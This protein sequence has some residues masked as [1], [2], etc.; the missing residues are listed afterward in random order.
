MVIGGGERTV[1]SDALGCLLPGLTIRGEGAAFV[2]VT[3]AS[4]IATSLPHQ[5]G[6]VGSEI[7]NTDGRVGRKMRCGLP[8]CVRCADGWQALA[9]AGVLACSVWRALTAL[10]FEP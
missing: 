2:V 3:H 5:G 9:R 1:I 7:T 8:C 10:W 4:S 6:R